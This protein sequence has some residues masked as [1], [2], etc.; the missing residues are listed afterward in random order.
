MADEDKKNFDINAM[1]DRIK[2]SRQEDRNVP[3]S[4]DDMFADDDDISWSAVASSSNQ[5]NRQNVGGSISSLADAGINFGGKNLEEGKFAKENLENANFSAANLS[6]VDFSGANL[7]GVDFSGA[8]LT[9]ANLEGADLSGAILSGS[10][11]IRTN[12]TGAKL[13]GIILTDAD[14][15]DA[16]LLD[17]EIDDLGLEELQALVEYLAKYFPHKLNLQ[18]LNLS[19]LDLTKIDLRNLNLRGV[20]FTGIDFTGVNI[21]ELDLSECIITPQQVAQA[22]GRVPNAE[23]LKRIMAPKKKPNKFKGLEIADMFMNDGRDYGVWD[24]TKDFTSIDD[25]LKIGKKVFRRSAKRPR[26]KDEEVL[27]QIKSQTKAEDKTHNAELR[28]VIEERKRQELE[29]RREK[30]QEFQNEVTRENVKEE[31]ERPAAKVNHNMAERIMATRDR[32]RD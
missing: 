5:G 23:E 14:I 3:K 25:L 15:Q 27:E 17:I 16:I 11:L 29:A 1:R 24:F 2:S 20:D 30:K 19:L 31:K 18:R 6:G 21:M 7:R 26:V 28:K 4:F 12:F 22:M 13:K 9:D 10:Q 32:S 8:N